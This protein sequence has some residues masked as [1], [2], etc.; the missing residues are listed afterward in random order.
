MQKIWSLALILILLLL[1]LCV[2]AEGEQYASGEPFYAYFADARWIRTLPQ[3]NTP[4]VVYVPE[5][6]MLLLTPVDDKYAATSYEGKD[7]YI[8]MRD[9]VRV[10]YT[11]PHS[12]QAI[13]VEGFFDLPAHMRNS[14][15]RNSGQI[16]TLPSD[17]RFRITYVN[18]EYAY[19]SYDG[20]EGFVSTDSFVQ[21]DYEKGSYEPYIGF[22]EEETPAYDSPCY[23]ATVCALIV[24]YS[25]LTVTGYDGDHL[26]VLYQNQQLYVEASDVTNL[27]DDYIVEPFAAMLKDNAAVTAYPLQNSGGLGVLPANTEVTVD[28]FHGEYAHVLTQDTVGYIHYS[29]LTSN[30]AMEEEFRRFEEQLARIEAQRF[31]NVAFTMLEENNPI[32]LAYNQNLGG[33]VKARFQYGCP[34]LFAG[35]HESSLLRIRFPSQNSHYYST[36]KRYLGGF[37]CIGFANWVHNKAGLKKLPHIHDT[38]TADPE[39]IVDVSGLPVSQWTQRLKVGD[40]INIG[41]KS[42][43]YHIMIYIGTLRSFGFTEEQVGMLAPYLDYPLTIHCGMNNFHTAWYTQY[44]ADNQMPNVTPP[45]GGVTISIMGIP[46]ADAPYT[47]TMWEGTSNV[48]TFYWFDLMGYNLTLNNPDAE[49]VSWFAVYRNK[50]Q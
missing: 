29:Q 25:P 20:Q 19:L 26:T 21:M 15:I 16:A 6:T 32:L 24:P 4:T 47:E 14:P 17:V 34:Y 49:N 9:V 44:I 48:H 3:A 22:C 1:P 31:L 37:D 33:D 42:G 28:A 10:E 2:L 27:N 43:G 12:P 36:E 45:D 5:R 30:E 50:E 11:D 8:Y 7:G 39:Y 38:K 40:C 35:M 41:F 13:T 18:S 23:G 46:Y